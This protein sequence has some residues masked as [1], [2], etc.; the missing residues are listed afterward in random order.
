MVNGLNTDNLVKTVEAVKENWELG[1]TVWKASTSWKGGF[2][3]ET[4]S[5]EFALNV[6]EPE[7]LCGTNT[8]ANPVEMVLQAYGACLLIGYAMNAT[9]RGI[10]IDD[11]KI[12]LEGEIDLPGF[13]GLEPPENLQMGKLP[14]YKNIKAEVTIKADADE[15]TLQE[16]HEHVVGT[17]P[18]GVTLSRPINIDA[19]LNAQ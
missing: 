19:K 9:A 2:K 5:R 6:D 17:S 1:K 10:K 8:A 14:G 4:C 3:I 18:V 12:D 16:L 11:I 13:L 7:M 15:K